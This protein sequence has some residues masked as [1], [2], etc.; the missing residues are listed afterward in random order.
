MPAI[1]NVVLSIVKN[2]KPPKTG[3]CAAEV[4]RELQVQNYATDLVAVC[5]VL[6]ELERRAYLKSALVDMGPYPSRRVYHY[7]H[8]WVRS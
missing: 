1:G 3:L 2:V 8:S 5:A 7:Q 4:L 6:A